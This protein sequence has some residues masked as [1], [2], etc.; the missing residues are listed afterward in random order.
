MASSMRKIAAVVAA[1]AMLAPAGALLAPASASASTS[2]HA[3]KHRPKATCAAARRGRRRTHTASRCHT[4]RRTRAR[5]ALVNPPRPGARTHAIA[6]AARTHLP[7]PQAQL[8]PAGTTTHCDLVAAPSGSDA[9][10]DGSAG[11][12]FASLSQLDNALHPG[13]TGCLR[14]GSYGGTDTETVLR[15]SGTADAHITIT[16]YPGERPVLNGRM[17]LE[18]SADFTTL[19]YLSFDTSNTVHL[20]QRSGT[21]CAPQSEGFV[22]AGHDNTI[23][24]DNVYQ[25]VANLRS[26]GIGVGWW[27]NAD[28][29]V[30]RY[31][32]IHDVGACWAFD[33][34]IYLS[35]GNNV[36]IYGNWMWNDP[37]GWG[38]QLYP[39]PTNARIFDNVIDA[40]GS[41]FTVGN[42]QGNQVS[43]NHI[44]HNVVMDSTGLAKAGLAGDAVSASWGGAPGGDNVFSDNDSYNNPGR[45]G[46]PSNVSLSGNSSADPK[47]VDA[48]SHDFRPQPGSPVGS[49]GLWNGS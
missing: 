28:N 13:Q 14:G 44:W 8:P 17:V 19:S 30:I 49:W 11:N 47:L 46:S 27:G 5:F 10:G 41:G 42:E 34:V 20:A 35:H 7:P 3:V 23:D 33:H 4:T 48:A 12:P 45:V 43:G 1:T 24:H 15:N 18:T 39:A 38:V 26:N 2:A 25:S 6:P 32:R 21:N 36:Q 22:I 40:A 37:H 31:S 16:A 29:T 9:R